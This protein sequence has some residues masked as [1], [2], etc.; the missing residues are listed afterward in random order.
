M[1]NTGPQGLVAS[2]DILMNTKGCC[3]NQA[4]QFVPD[5]L[6]KMPIAWAGQKSGAEQRFPELGIS[7]GTTVGGDEEEEV[8]MG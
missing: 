1:L 6:I 5:W 3:V 2:D 8:T 7:T 4:S